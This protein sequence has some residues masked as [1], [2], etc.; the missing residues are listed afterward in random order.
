MDEV[1]SEYLRAIANKA[2]EI[3]K[4]SRWGTSPDPD[5]I[6]EIANQIYNDA[7]LAIKTLRLSHETKGP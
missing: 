5:A 3:K 2:H 1:L 6:F 4:L 7:F